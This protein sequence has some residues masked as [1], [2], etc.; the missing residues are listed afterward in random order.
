MENIEFKL[1]DN[2][3]KYLQ[4]YNNIKDMIQQGKL[5]KNQKLI[6]IR[7]LSK[8]LGVNTST[9]VKAYDLLEYEGYVYKVAGSGCYVKEVK[10]E[11]SYQI[12][13]YKRQGIT[14]DS[15]TP[16]LDIF[17]IEDFKKAINMCLEKEGAKIFDYEDGL[18][19][20]KLRSSICDYLKD[21]KIYSHINKIQIISGAQQGI[22]LICKAILSYGD[23]A[24]VEMPTY[25]G[26]IE[27]FKTKGVKAIQIPMLEDGI[28]IGI[29]KKKL[30]KLRP[31]LL[32]LMPNYQNPT[33]ISYSKQKKEKIIDLAKEYDFYIIEDD[34]LSDFKFDSDDNYTLRHYDKYNKVIYIKSFSKLLMPG[35]RIG[36]MEVPSNLITKLSIAKH[37]SDISTSGLVQ[38]ALYYY[39]K[40]F[41]WKTHLMNLEK[42]YKIRFDKAKY[43][44]ENNL[45]GPLEYIKPKGGINFF[46]GLPRGYSSCDFRDYLSNYGVFI[47]PG[48]HFFENEIESR[49]F[50]INI[51]STNE[52]EIEKGIQIISSKLSE[53]LDKY[54]NNLDFKLNEIYF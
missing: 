27:V 44:I 47:L 50:R 4:I 33:G 46:L 6:P 5:K 26:A 11:E 10:K 53:F 23:F 41:D 34:F 17:P 35:L 21:L 39:I 31:K 32:Y 18:G 25:S 42:I 22:D 36:F 29:L 48:G 14:F 2:L 52:D 20:L 37:S 9:I 16:S 7:K 45:K 40:Y 38:G 28:D 3:P 43:L 54:K 30:E 51:A 49:F 12:H 15:A 1:D 19:N 24:F 8:I 13:D